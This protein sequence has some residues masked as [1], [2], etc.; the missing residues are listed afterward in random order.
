M[1]SPVSAPESCPACALERARLAGGLHLGRRPRL[2]YAETRTA[3][4]LPAVQADAR[5]PRRVSYW[6][7]RRLG[8]ARA[9]RART[10]ACTTHLIE[11]LRVSARR[12]GQIVSLLRPQEDPATP[13]T[14]WSAPEARRARQEAALAA[15]LARPCS[16]CGA[17]VREPCRG[18]HNW[19][20]LGKPIAYLHLARRTA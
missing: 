8:E 1:S 2:S 14:A 15:A 16:T 10:G 18:V 9:V 20:S 7:S 17:V 13:F 5:P 6:T 12:A 11:A 19:T 4:G 3:L